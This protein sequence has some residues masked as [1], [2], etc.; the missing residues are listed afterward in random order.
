MEYF[1]SA[2]FLQTLG[3]LALAILIL[4]G[5]RSLDAKIIKK[6]SKNQS[7]YKSAKVVIEV[8]N[9]VLIVII[10]LL[11]LDVNGVDV[12]KMIRSLGVIG[13]VVGFAL[14]DLLKDLIMGLSIMFEDYY[15][16]GDI[17]IY[18][19]KIGKV[20]SFNVKTTKL[21]LLETEETL[22]VSNRNITE[23]S[24]ASDWLDVDVN[25]G[26][27]VDPITSRALCQECAK[28]IE[29]LRYVYICDFI[30]TQELAESWITYRLRIH[31]LQ[32]KRYMVKRNANAV[33]QDVFFEKGIP[34]PL[35][36]KVLVDNEKLQLENKAL[37]ANKKPISS[38][39]KT[40]ELGRGAE[41]SK[42]CSIDGSEGSIEKAIK[43]AERYSRSENLDKKM[44]LRIRLLS[45]ELLILSKE[46]ANLHDGKYQIIREREDYL[47]DFSALADVTKKD[48]K[49]MKKNNNIYEGVLGRLQY[50]LESMIE[51]SMNNGNS[52]E[53]TDETIG[54]SDEDYRWSYKVYKETAEDNK[55]VNEDEIGRSVITAFADD[56]KIFVRRNH[57]NIKILV[58]NME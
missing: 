32:E 12:T 44:Q 18:Q 22:S 24:V 42:V 25:I 51:L 13:I 6:K 1:L 38:S 52:D 36:I 27:D 40:Y 19:G 30:N 47:I 48:V 9:I 58:K 14:N 28:R 33:V 11:A 26:Y 8:V 46:M 29:R 2:E 54:K 10:I 23:I 21:F 7:W 20:V 37:K 49:I 16:V 43:E 57:V 39:N 3:L 5:S 50:A 4:I 55:T 17:V 53:I 45:E 35:S 41:Q 15:K 56:V 34:F 31:C